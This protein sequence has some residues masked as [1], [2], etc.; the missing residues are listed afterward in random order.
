MFA[1]EILVDAAPKRIVPTVGHLATTS[2]EEGLVIAE[3][4][5]PL[6]FVG[7]LNELARVAEETD[8]DVGA[9]ARVGTVGEVDL[10]ECGKWEGNRAEVLVILHRVVVHELERAAAQRQNLLLRLIP[11]PG[12]QLVQVRRLEVVPNDIRDDRRLDKGEEP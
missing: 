7:K 10:E 12:I 11:V 6:V 8:C 3:N 5:G 4:R 1:L 9:I 2:R